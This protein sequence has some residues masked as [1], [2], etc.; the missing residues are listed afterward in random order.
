M[1]CIPTL[2]SA[3]VLRWQPAQVLGT[4]SAGEVEQEEWKG[5]GMLAP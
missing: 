3:Q 4:A 2:A 1:S 5:A